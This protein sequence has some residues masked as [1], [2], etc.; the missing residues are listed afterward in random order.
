MLDDQANGETIALLGGCR[1]EQF[2]LAL[3]VSRPSQRPRASAS[4][5]AKG[6]F[7]NACPGLY[8]RKALARRRIW[9][10]SAQSGPVSHYADS[11]REQEPDLPAETDSAP[12]PLL[13]VVNIP[14]RADD[15][16]PSWPGSRSSSWMAASIAREYA[17]LDSDLALNPPPPLGW[18]AGFWWPAWRLA[19]RQVQRDQPL[20]AERTSSYL[21]QANRELALGGQ[22]S[23]VGAVPR[24]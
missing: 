15:G 16:T 19:F 12:T 6:E 1:G 21:L 20:L 22:T 18:G 10:P 9:R 8:L 17:R 11:R 13:F 2:S 4:I 5:L 7:V 3:K 23:A 14:L 24:T